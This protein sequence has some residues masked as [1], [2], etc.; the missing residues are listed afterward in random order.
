MTNNNKDNQTLIENCRSLVSKIS[1]ITPSHIL[2][3]DMEAIEHAKE[4]EQLERQEKDKFR[5][6]VTFN[7]ELGGESGRLRDV[8]NLAAQLD[9]MGQ[10]PLEGRDILN[11]LW[12]ELKYIMDQIDE[13]KSLP[14]S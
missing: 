9:I 1:R 5:S 3:K 4:H 12:N 11:D 6:N 14:I 2:P 7:E 10:K 8:N 13:L